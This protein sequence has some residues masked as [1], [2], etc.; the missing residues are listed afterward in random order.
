[1]PLLQQDLVCVLWAHVLNSFSLAG[2]V[3]YESVESLESGKDLA[4]R[5]RLFKKLLLKMCPAYMMFRDKD[6]AEMGGGMANQ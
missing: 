5:C 3:S 2:A 4:R 6:G 1:M